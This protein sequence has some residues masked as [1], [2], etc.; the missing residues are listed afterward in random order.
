M[1]LNRTERGG[2]RAHL[3][4]AAL[5]AGA[6]AAS[7][8]LPAVTPLDDGRRLAASLGADRRAELAHGVAW[9]G[10]GVV[11]LPF[12][13]PGAQ[14]RIRGAVVVRAGEIDDVRLFAAREG[15]DRR[16]LAAP[17]WLASFRG[18]KIDAPVAVDAISG[19][20]ISSQALVDAIERRLRDWRERSR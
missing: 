13:E 9:T 19:A 3:I 2:A 6:L 4:T 5:L 20:T 15:V 11:V 8:A 16:A 1:G 10:E 12:D 17:T 18:M 14:G 7:R